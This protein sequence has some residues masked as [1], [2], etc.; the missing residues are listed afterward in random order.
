MTQ[1]PQ[2]RQ[3]WTL[4]W[5]ER[6]AACCLKEYKSDDGRLNGRR[7]RELA[8][9]V[10]RELQRAHDPHEELVMGRASSPEMKDLKEKL[11]MRND[12]YKDTKEEYHMLCKSFVRTYSYVK[13]QDDKIAKC[14][15]QI[16]CGGEAQGLEACLRQP[17]FDI[18]EDEFEI[19]HDRSPEDIQDACKN[20]KKD[21]IWNDVRIKEDL[22]LDEPELQEQITRNATQHIQWYLTQVDLTEHVSETYEEQEH[23]LQDGE[24]KRRKRFKRE[25]IKH[26]RARFTSPSTMGN[27]AQQLNEV[28]A[29]HHKRQDKVVLLK[30]LSKMLGSLATQQ[31]HFRKCLEK[32]LQKLSSF[33]PCP[34]LLFEEAPSYMND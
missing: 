28:D 7:L 3:A 22:R 4:Q 8:D 5:L 12:V 18:L 30:L 16:P 9:T 29:R 15:R 23:C 13:K 27:I 34:A 26:A 33:V 25:H 31:K 21:G 11:D 6:D 20:I 10:N 2:R 19:L 17:P 32:S 24:I 1:P 14:L